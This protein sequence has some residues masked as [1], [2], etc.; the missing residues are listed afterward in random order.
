[1]SRRI[2]KILL[3]APVGPFA[4]GESFLRAFSA[5]G[6]EVALVNYLDYFPI[7]AGRAERLIRRLGRGK[8]IADYNRALRDNAVGLQPQLL[9][10]AK[11]NLFT[12]ETLTEIRERLPETILVNI[13][14]DD[15]FSR[16]PSNR[17]PDIKRQAPLYDW[18]F[19]SKSANVEELLK[20]QAPRVRYLPL[21]YDET[22]H[23]PVRPNR[24]QVEEYSSEVIFAG[25]GTGERAD[26]LSALTD[27]RLAV[28]GGHW[29]GEFLPSE[30]R[31]VV[32]RTGRNR[33]VR[34]T[35]LS[36]ILNSSKIGLNFLREDNR[37]THN[38]R[39]F[40]L[41]ACGVFTLSQRS[42]E[43]ESFFAEDLEMVYFSSRE[44]L[45]EKVAYYLEHDRER[46]EIARAGLRRVR[47]GGYTIRDR[48]ASMLSIMELK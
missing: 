17:F 36:I 32:R 14:Y 48:V 24:R 44:E 7:E 22:A 27:Y 25:T 20:L 34:G 1:M 11:G 2:E 6:K 46:E 5:L 28:W 45:G 23:Y 10:I 42:E 12:P 26:W 19:P 29:G 18:I 16:A 9:I 31:R 41:P 47:A 3:A 33:I 4:I 30:L 38:H 39:S 43:L 21:G 37:D 8:I 15:F 35:E 40:E 13:N